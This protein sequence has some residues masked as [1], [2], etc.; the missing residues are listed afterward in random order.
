MAKFANNQQRR[1]FFGKLREKKKAD[2]VK[3]ELM[4]TRAPTNKELQ[5]KQPVN[6]YM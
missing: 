6:K 5:T 3:K 1:A 2:D 4:A